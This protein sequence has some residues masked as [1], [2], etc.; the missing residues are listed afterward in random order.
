MHTMSFDSIMRVTL[1]RILVQESSFP[2]Q[3]AN[4]RRITQTVWFAAE[5]FYPVLDSRV[6]V[7]I[8]SFHARKGEFAKIISKFQR[9]L[10]YKTYLLELLMSESQTKTTPQIN[11]PPS[12]SK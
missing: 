6:F 11:L 12:S 2:H 10:D 4:I 3:L 9:S 7:F 5:N 1:A 8:R